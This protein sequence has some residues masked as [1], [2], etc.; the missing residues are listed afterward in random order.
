MGG[1]TAKAALLRDGTPDI[2]Q[3]YYVGGFANGIPVRVPVVDLI[4]VGAGGGS[5]A[6]LDVGGALS[7]GPAERRRP[8]RPRL[9]RLGR[10]P[11]DGHRRQRRARPP[12]PRPLPRRRDGPRRGRC[13]RRR[14]TE[15]VGGTLGLDAEEAALAV[16]NI[17]VNMMGLAVRQ[18]SV[19]RGVDP[20]DCALIAF[21]GAGPLHACA[22]AREVRIP[23][24]IV[25]MLPGHFSALGHAPRRHP[26]RAGA[27]DLRDHRGGRPRDPDARSPRRCPTRSGTCSRQSSSPRTTR[28]SSSTW[29]FATRDRSSPSAPRARRPSWGPAWTWTRSASGSTS[30]TSC[31]SATTRP[32]RPS[33]SSTCA[34]SASA[35]G[36]G[37]DRPSARPPATSW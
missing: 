23:R 22:V 5:I 34:W 6:H 37:S 29:T 16:I 26:P 13:R 7:V 25:P 11:A 36:S 33:R 27:H 19:E 21:G 3:G 8:A 10:R 9:L 12:Q 28:S 4:E 2:A 24:V 20:R 31:A 18:V 15:Q 17:A 35:A 32:A 30:S 14:S 1:T